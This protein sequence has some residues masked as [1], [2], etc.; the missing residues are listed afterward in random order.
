MGQLSASTTHVYTAAVHA[1]SDLTP[2]G[3]VVGGDDIA[4][5]VAAAPEAEAPE[6]APKASLVMGSVAR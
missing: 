5:P 4:A 3:F 2:A 6:I 1:T